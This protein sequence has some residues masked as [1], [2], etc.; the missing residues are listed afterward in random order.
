[1]EITSSS[2]ILTSTKRNPTISIVKAIGIILMVIGHSG[3][4]QWLHNYIYIFHMPLFFFCSGYFFK[5]INNFRQ[6]IS[7]SKKK[8]KGLYLPY[9]KW[10]IIFL[11]LHNIFFNLNIYNN[12]Y[13]F[14]NIVSQ[15]YSATDF[16]KKILNIIL[17]MRGAEQLLGGFWF[18]RVLFLSSILLAIISQLKYKFKISHSTIVICLLCILYFAKISHLRAPIIG[19]I[20]LILYGI[21]FLYLGYLYK[22]IEK[23][24]FYKISTFLLLSLCVAVGSYSNYSNMLLFEYTDIASYIFFATLGI[25]SIFCISSIFTKQKI[26]TPLIYIGDNT[27]IILSLHFLSFKLVSLFKIFIFNL[28][29]KQLA[30]F[31]VI[32]EY[33]YI[34]WIL[35]SIVGICLPL[36]LLCLY[37]KLKNKFNIAI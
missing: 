1:M 17:A 5:P 36:T 34:F 11:L 3:C 27:M 6:V 10:C 29:F 23:I 26:A 12:F 15:P 16:I 18:L 37:H 21:I 30:C 14:N 13:G 7:F 32:N 20:P 33:N 4:P 9:I 24:D 31:P 2:N 19:D 22:K 28:S 8:I 25:L 35:Y